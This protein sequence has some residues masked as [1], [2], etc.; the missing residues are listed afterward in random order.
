MT[1]ASPLY[2]KEQ[3]TLRGSCFSVEVVAGML[4]KSL[5]AL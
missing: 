1:Q 4:A 2:I 5:H 3:L